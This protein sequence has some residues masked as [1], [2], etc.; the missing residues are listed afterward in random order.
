MYRR[1]ISQR[2]RLLAVGG[3]AVSAMLTLAACSAGAAGDDPSDSAE[4]VGAFGAPANQPLE[5]YVF[6]GGYGAE[7]TDKVVELYNKTIP[8]SEVEVNAVQEIATQLQPRFVSG[9][10]PDLIDNSGTGIEIATLIDGGQLLDLTELLEAPSYDDPN[11]TVG[12][13]LTDG[14]VQSGTY[15]GKLLELRFVN[16]AYGLWYSQS[17]FEE[18]GWELPTTWNDFIALGEEAKAE[19][20]A[21]F[22]YP[23][24]VPSYVADVLVAHIGKQGGIEALKAL[25]NL[26]AG[27][28]ESDVVVDAFAAL[29]ELNEKDLILEG[30]EALSHTEA[31]TEFVL[32]KALFYPT[33]SWLENEMKGITPEGFDMAIAPVPLL[34]EST[35]ALDYAAL[36][37]VPG[38]PFIVPSEGKNP[39]G[40]LEYLRSMLSKESAAQFSKLTGA[41][42]VVK[43]SLEGV[44]VTSALQTVTEAIEAGGNPDLRVMFR[45][46][47]EEIRTQWFTTLG[48]VLAGRATPEEAAATMQAVADKVAADDSVTKYTRD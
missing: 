34:D 8:G 11:V 20:L 16:T 2:R 12:E 28:W 5:V 42:T 25:D 43:G 17:L 45:G 30:S 18:H 44:E 39:K 41:P 9:N 14:V 27:A 22:A 15:E 48:D 35:A 47:Y 7:Y 13:T 32:G 3:L 33:G 6:D 29:A 1:P 31:Q 37:V 38:E 4:G 26:E 46:W 19:G 36:Q 24:Q 40:A 23:G 10:A 21:L